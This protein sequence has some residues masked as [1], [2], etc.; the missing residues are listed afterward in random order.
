ML[1]NYKTWEGRLNS[2]INLTLDNKSLFSVFQPIYSFS[3]QACIGVEALVRGRS[4][5]TGFQLPVVDCL[6]VPEGHS[7]AVFNLKLNQMHLHNW[8]AV[9]SPNTWLFLNLDIQAVSNLE[10]LCIGDLI[11]EQQLLGHEVVVEVVENEIVDESLFLP[12]IERLRQQGCLIALDDFG[13]GHSNID[14]IWK[15]QPDIVKLDR[16]VLIEATRSGRSESILRNLTRLIKQAGSVSLLEGIE[17][18]EQAML[19][20]DVGVDLVQGYYF[21]RP[22]PLLDQVQQG[23]SRL[24]DIIAC[25]PDYLEEQKK[26]NRQHQ[27]S[28]QALLDAVEEVELFSELEFKM[29]QAAQ[30]SIVKRFYILDDQGYQISEDYNQRV[31]PDCVDVLRKGKGLCWRNRNYYVRAIAKPE[32]VFVSEPYRSLIDMQLCLTVSKVVKLAGSWFVACFDVHY[33]DRS[34]D[35]EATTTS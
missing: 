19:A 12:I 31:S 13:A 30:H 35:S 15:I 5:T 21:A 33:F 4:V 9:R 29:A 22:Q 2:T 10:D 25:Y 7:S 8:Q 27:A 3:N 1:L 17:T 34:M 32:D 26:R 11:A 28:Y 24:E 18:K 16:G 23:Q 6:T 14:R 20:M